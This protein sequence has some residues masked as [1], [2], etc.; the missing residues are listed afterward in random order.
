M[1]VRDWYE[2][3]IAILLCAGFGTRMY[4][5]T[6]NISKPLLKVA[7]KPVIDY[8]LD[9]I[10]RFRELE[11]IYIV[12]NNRFYSDY[13]EW[14]ISWQSK[15]DET[16]IDIFLFNNGVDDNNSRRGAISDLAFVL[17]SGNLYDRN[18]L[19]SAGDN[20]FLFDMTNFWEE[21]VKI[22]T[23]QLFALK[24]NNQDQ[25][26]RSG[27]IMLND[28]NKVINFQEKPD[29]PGSHWLCPALYFLTG[30]GL[31]LLNRYLQTTNQQ[32]ALGDFIKYLVLSTDVFANPI[33]DN[34]RYDIG[35]IEDYQLANEILE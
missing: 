12:V 34:L 31:R 3:M 16:G 14:R 17:G 15:I 24:V 26:Q 10:M 1:K 19:V 11:G 20:I 27:V 13:V 30:N 18:A 28:D 21:F 5:L 8:L 33:Q 23:N 9:Q 7:G 32:D 35:S 22:P 2:L 25:L 4:P 29:I 6:K